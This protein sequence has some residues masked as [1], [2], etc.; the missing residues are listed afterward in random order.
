MR[1]PFFPLDEEYPCCHRTSSWLLTLN[2]RLFQVHRTNPLRKIHTKSWNVLRA[3]YEWPC[4]PIHVRWGS[5]K[6]TSSFTASGEQNTDNTS[7][8]PQSFCL[9]FARRRWTGWTRPHHHPTSSTML[10]RI[11]IGVF[12]KFLTI[13]RKITRLLSLAFRK[14]VS[15]SARCV[16]SIGCGSKLLWFCELLLFLN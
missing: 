13:F 16:E 9:I 2:H 6:S 11:V 15:T 8:P 1:Y 12:A 4:H 7:F 14:H 3:G 10:K 5:G